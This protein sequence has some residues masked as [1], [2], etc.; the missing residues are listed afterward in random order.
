MTID[1]PITGRPRF[2][3]AF[4]AQFAEL[5]RWRRERAQVSGPIRFAADLIARLL[6]LAVCAPSVG[7]SQPL[8]FRAGRN[9]TAT[10]G[11]R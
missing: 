4:K 3:K 7:L 1:T 10:A 8:A 6:A 11:D 9:A 5:V 2:D